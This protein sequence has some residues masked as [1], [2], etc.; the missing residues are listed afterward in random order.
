PAGATLSL[1]LA[2]CGIKVTLVEREGDFE[3]VFR[4]EALM[5]TGLAA[6][7][8]IGLGEKLKSLP[9][10]LLE[11]WEI[12]LDTIQ[13]MNIREPSHELGDR[14]LRVIPQP[15]LLTLLVTEAQTYGCFEFRAPAT[16]RDLLWDGDRVCGVTIASPAGQSDLAADLVIGTDGRASVV[17]K[18]ADL[19][20]TLLPESYDVLWFKLPIPPELQGRCPIQIFASGAEV[21]LAYVSWD[22]RFQLAWILPKGAWPEV[23]QRD[24]LS[25]CV[26][27]FP[28]PLAHHVLKHRDELAGPSLLDVIVGRCPTWSRPGVMLL[29]DAAHPMSP[30]RAQGINMALRD[31]IVAANHLIPAIRTNQELTDALQNLQHERERE[32]VKIQRLQLREVRGQRWARARPWL[33][34][35]LLRVTPFLAKTGLIQRL[36]LR[37]QHELRFGVTEVTLRV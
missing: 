3:R 14:A 11:S 12:Y 17:R 30:V 4:G 18:R 26:R 5:P 16:V 24:W 34:K 9:S 22:N 15:Q 31:A 28:V 36:W 35:P 25:E 33:V 29:G 23:R 21:A 8:Q 37:Q 19:S 2:R 6:L 32:I 1:L 13:I 10:R 7:A 20:L 27:L